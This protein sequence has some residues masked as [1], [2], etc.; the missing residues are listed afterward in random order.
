MIQIFSLSV[1]GKDWGLWNPKCFEVPMKSNVSV[2][3]FLAA[4]FC[5]SL[6]TL[7]LAQGCKDFTPFFFFLLE[8]EFKFYILDPSSVLS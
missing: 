1:A 5:A 6:K 7:S 4:A 3:S 8:A 2:F